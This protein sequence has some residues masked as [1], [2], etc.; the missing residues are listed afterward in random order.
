L[1]GVDLPSPS[2]PDLLGSLDKLIGGG[3]GIFSWVSQLLGLLAIIAVA[4]LLYKQGVCS[5]GK[6]YGGGTDP[7]LVRTVAKLELEVAELKKKQE[8][9]KEQKEETQDRSSDSQEAKEP[10]VRT[11]SRPTYSNTPVGTA[12]TV[13][14]V[15][16]VPLPT[17]AS[18]PLPMAPVMR[19]PM[20]ATSIRGPPPAVA[21]P[22]AQYV[23]MA[24]LDASQ[25]SVAPM[26]PLQ[27]R[28]NI[29][30]PRGVNPS[31]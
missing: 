24:N 22:P 2:A 4:Y 8:K 1:F 21:P 19:A 23:Q 26:G 6:Q 7:E 16:Y 20:G 11:N 18:G 3:F 13:P 27:T 30:L 9:A 5:R 29:R 14:T 10:V 17:T 28:I 25:Q 15:Q 12:F 31:T